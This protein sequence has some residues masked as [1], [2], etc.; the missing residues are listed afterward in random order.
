MRNIKWE[1]V[2]ICILYLEEEEDEEELKS[3]MI[4][5]LEVVKLNKTLM[6][7]S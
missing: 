4:K 5:I 6:M 7:R 3:K 1:L 2:I